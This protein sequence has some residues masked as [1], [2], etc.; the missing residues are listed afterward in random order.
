MTNSEKQRVFRAVENTYLFPFATNEKIKEACKEAIEYNC[1]AVCVA[2]SMV[3]LA[4]LFLDN[5]KCLYRPKLTTVIGFPFGN[6]ST[7]M[8]VSECV[9]AVKSG[10]DEVNVV[11]NYGDIANKEFKRI[12]SEI[13]MLK[14]CSEGKILKII[15]NCSP[16]TEEEKIGLCRVINLSDAD[17]I[18]LS[19]GY[20]PETTVIEDVLFFKAYLSPHIKIKSSGGILTVEDG[21]KFLNCGVDRLGSSAILKNSK[22]RDIKYY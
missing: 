1:S 14:I 19:S 7:H 11:I 5:G 6:I 12:L 15:I 13:N 17:Y 21:L 16:L 10:A 4:K 8:K 22:E 2:P 9:S 20:F 3:H 18:Q